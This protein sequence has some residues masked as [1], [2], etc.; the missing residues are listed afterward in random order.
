MMNQGARALL[1]RDQVK[2]FIQAHRWATLTVLRRNGSPVSSIVAYALY[3]GE[4]VVSTPGLTFK[5]LA[6]EADPRVNL[7]IMSN[8]EPFDF[9][10]LEAQAEVLETGIAA[11]TIKVFENI[12]PLGFETPDPL[13]DW[14]ARGSRVILRITPDR[15]HAVLRRFETNGE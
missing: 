7:C 4:I 15:G 3:D 10:S 12:A 8:E 5:R 11:P 9:V 1:E 14:L 2:R 6:I 13:D